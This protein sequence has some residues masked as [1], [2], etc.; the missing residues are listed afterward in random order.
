MFYNNNMSAIKMTKIALLSVNTLFPGQRTGLWYVTDNFIAPLL[1]EERVALGL[2]WSSTEGWYLI[3]VSY[4]VDGQNKLANNEWYVFKTEPRADADIG[5]EPAFDW[6]C[7]TFAQTSD[8]FIPLMRLFCVA[9]YPFPTLGGSGALILEYV[10]HQLWVYLP[11]LGS[12]LF[13][14]F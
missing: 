6:L 3:I 1:F 10:L 9:A 8:L 5:G 7:N 11:P 13:F 4:P 2:G 12:K 14:F